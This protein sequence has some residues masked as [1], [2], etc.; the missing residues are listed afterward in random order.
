[1]PKSR[2]EQDIERQIRTLRA[3]IESELDAIYEEH[4]TIPKS[5]YARFDKLGRE[6][7]RLIQERARLR[8]HRVR[9]EGRMV[10]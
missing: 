1:M 7:D 6:H 10:Y 2:A 3:R 9:D 8:S 5:E 4:K